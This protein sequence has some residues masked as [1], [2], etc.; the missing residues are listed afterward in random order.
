MIELPDSAALTS[1]P[2]ALWS[3]TAALRFNATMQKI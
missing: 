1:M 2:P 3:L